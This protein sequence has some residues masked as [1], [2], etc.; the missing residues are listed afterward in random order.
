MS[1]PSPTIVL[2][3]GA[4]TDA[5]VWHQVIAELHSRSYRVLAPAMPLRGLESDAAYLRSFLDTIDGSVVVAAH[6]YG[7]SIISDPKALTE[8]VQALVF[9]A[10]FQQD[11]GESAGELD[12]RFPGSML[13]PDTTL[14]H[15]S[16]T[17]TDLYLR[18]ED[19]A[20]I[21]GADLGATRAAVMAAAQKPINPAAFEET[22]SDT[23]SWRSLPSWA[24]IPTADNSIPTRALRFMAE[25]AGSTV[26]E[27]RSS[28]AVP[29]TRPIE[30]ADVIAAAATGPWTRH[31]PAR[32]NA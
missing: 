24:L 10:A 21:Y 4:L 18:S 26:L 8:A 31:S 15:E 2:V 6:S 22:L 1:E 16:A 27:T 14:V 19:F 17:G 5:S 30:T 28:H 32:A 9:I 20:E 11:A 25:R 29:L 7:G 3:H 12:H 23:P 13:V